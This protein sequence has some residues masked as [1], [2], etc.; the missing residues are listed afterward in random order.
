MRPAENIV[1]S[2]SCHSG[3]IGY[4]VGMLKKCLWLGFVL[5]AVAAPAATV[6]L[7]GKASVTGTILAEKR[8]HIIVDIGYTVLIIPRNQVLKLLND[9]EAAA[10]TVTAPV[11]VAPAPTRQAAARVASE[12]GAGEG[13]YKTP[14]AGL[15][16]RT[17]RELVD[18][19]GEA[20]VQV[21]T[22]AGLGSGFF[23]NADGY[24]I[25]NFHVTEG[26]TQISVE[27]Y[28]QK[29]GQLTRTDLQAGQDH[30]AEQVR[31]PGLAADRG[32]GRAAVR[33]RDAGGR[34]QAGGGGE[35][36]RHRQ[37]AGIG[38]GR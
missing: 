13:F 7:K 32:Q 37:P 21:R 16:D 1:I 18:D 27:V 9:N 11:A 23:I 6:E 26:E 29:D 30:R 8:D 20:V 2:G 33:Q 4:S 35:R 24:L 34:G 28:H 31:R 22:P 5:Y 15:G 10:K 19:L 14:A 36:V 25:T 17:V 3:G 38:D 12:P